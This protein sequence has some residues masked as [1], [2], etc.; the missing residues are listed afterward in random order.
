LHVVTDDCLELKL[1]GTRR[2]MFRGMNNECVPE[3][4][5]KSAPSARLRI[6]Y[7][8]PSSGWLCAASLVMMATAYASARPRQ[9]I[10]LPSVTG[11]LLKSIFGATV[12]TIPRLL[13]IRLARRLTR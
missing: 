8:L 1:L 7:A 9:K 12:R 13:L 10:K 3:P 6:E 5:T 11:T 2:A 4:R